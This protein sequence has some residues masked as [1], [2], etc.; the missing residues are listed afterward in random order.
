MNENSNLGGDRYPIYLCAPV[1]ALVEG[2]YEERIPYAEIKKHGDFG[3]GTFDS[4]DGEMV[5]ETG[6]IGCRG[7]GRRRL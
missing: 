3:L 2:V 4:L 1:N 5:Y 7:K 6:S